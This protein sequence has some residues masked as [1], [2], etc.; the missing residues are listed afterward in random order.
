MF[1][2][3]GDVAQKA[4]RRREQRDEELKRAEYRKQLLQH[5]NDDDVEL[6]M[7]PRA[8]PDVKVEVPVW[9]W[10][11]VPFLR[12]EPEETLAKCRVNEDGIG[13]EQI[14]S[15]I[16]IRD[17][18]IT[19]YVHCPPPLQSL[20]GMKEPPVVPLMLTR[21][22][23]KKLRRQRRMEKMKE[24]Q[25]MIATGLLPAEAPKVKLS[26]MVRVLANESTADPTKVEAEVRKQVEERRRKHEMD[27]QARKKTKEERR[28][29]AVEKLEKDKEDGLMATV[30]RIVSMDTPQHR[31][32]VDI[33]ARQWQMTGI[34][35]L[36]P[37]M[38]IVVVE[39]GAK[40]LRKYKKLM[41]RRIDWNAK[42][43]GPNQEMEKVNGPASLANEEKAEENEEIS[44]TCVLVWEG[45]TAKPAFSDFS[46]VR[47]RNLRECRQIFRKHSVEHYWDLCLQ[48]NPIGNRNLGQRE[49]D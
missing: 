48:G 13:I 3:P 12:D 20:D 35:M 46:T 2:T 23:T 43:E 22:E 5:A 21:R 6:P 19:H 8:I 24:K 26:N 45:P 4:E 31:F 36:F 30:Y 15:A 42:T 33:N 16:H 28:D 40:A 38:N 41:L 44:N 18:R 32:K 37:E 7:L 27:N 11:D 17:D 1:H 14:A 49:I 29:K 25:E 10:W 47:P 9:E 34:L 39:G